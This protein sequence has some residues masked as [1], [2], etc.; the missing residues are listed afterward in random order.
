VGR[1]RAQGGPSSTTKVSGARD[2]AP[3]P[4]KLP[5]ARG[6]ALSLSLPPLIS[7]LVHCAR[8]H[9]PWHA[10]NGALLELTEDVQIWKVMSEYAVAPVSSGGSG[11]SSLK[12]DGGGARRRQGVCDGR[13]DEAPLLQL[14]DGRDS[15]TARRRPEEIRQQRLPRRASA[16][17]V[18][19]GANMPRSGL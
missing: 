8:C 3:P 7:V 2:P 10:D 19:S 9:V 5:L 17:R 16:N 15:P 6:A 11:G 12:R 4:S 1:R 13:D 18:R 14:R